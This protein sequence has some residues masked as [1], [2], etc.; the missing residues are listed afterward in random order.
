MNNKNKPSFLKRIIDFLSPKVAALLRL[1][2]RKYHVPTNWQ[3]CRCGGTFLRCFVFAIRIGSYVFVYIYLKPNEETN[4]LQRK[5]TLNFVLER[6]KLVPRPARSYEETPCCF[7]INSSC[8][9]A[10]SGGLCSPAP[11]HPVRR[12][13][14][15]YNLCIII[16]TDICHILT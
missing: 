11:A 10:E 12:P 5:A 15:F 14:L 8:S 3:P 1:P 9:I 13:A 6:P 7:Y 16:K 4:V 2:L